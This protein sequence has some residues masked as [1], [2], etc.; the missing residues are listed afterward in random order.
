[1]LKGT[2]YTFFIRQIAYSA[3]SWKLGDFFTALFDF[4]FPA[5]YISR[6]RKK[7]ENL[8]QGPKLIKEYISKLIEMFSIIGITHERTRITTLWFSLR[9]TIQQG[10]W[11]DH[12]NPE[13]SSWNDV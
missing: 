8:L 7:L 11:K 6:Q 3:T 10:L 4:C 13:T 5:D 2:A 12:L 9:P 1:F